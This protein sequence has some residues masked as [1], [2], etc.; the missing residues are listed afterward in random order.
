MQLVKEN[1]TSWPQEEDSCRKPTRHVEM[2]SRQ[3]GY[4]TQSRFLSTQSLFL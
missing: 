3:A 2:V 4:F 1:D